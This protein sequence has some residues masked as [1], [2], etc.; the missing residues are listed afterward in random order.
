MKRSI[1]DT[2]KMATSFISADETP[3]RSRFMREEED[4]GRQEM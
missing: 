2:S 3:L 1:G 4:S